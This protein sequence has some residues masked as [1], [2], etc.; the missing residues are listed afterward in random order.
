[1]YGVGKRSLPISSE[2]LAG[3][4]GRLRCCLRFEYE[5]YRQVTR[6]L[7]KFGEQLGTPNGSAT[8][9]VGHRMKETVSARYGDDPV[10]ELPLADV[11]RNQPSKN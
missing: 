8:V 10:R 6:V 5:Q 3:A 7:P 2:G 1:V 11:T 4:R 9:I